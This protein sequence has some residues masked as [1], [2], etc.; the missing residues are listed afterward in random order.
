MPA[1]DERLSPHFML[2][3][4]SRSAAHPDLVR[5]VPA[6]IV[7]VLRRLVLEVLEPIRRDIAKPMKI[8]SGYRS[9]DLNRAIG[10]S[11]TSQHV[12][13]EAADF[14]T[15]D[16]R[17][18][19][20]AILGMVADHRLR[21]AGQLIY[22]PSRGFIHVALPSGRFP[23]PTCCIHW[24]ERGASYAPI[25]PTLAAFNALVPGNLDPNKQLRIT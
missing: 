4:F 16:L 18:T 17:G 14:T 9:K 3:E 22:Y 10:G 25:T 11:V 8:L 6:D 13:G 2:S 7:Q 1:A 19:W 20:I 21:E 5:D 12:R 23:H 15:H 24:P